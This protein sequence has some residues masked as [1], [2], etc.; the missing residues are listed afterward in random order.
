MQHCN[1][2]VVQLARISAQLCYYSF[3]AMIRFWRILQILYWPKE[4]PS[5]VRT[6]TTDNR[7]QWAKR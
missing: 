5:W 6:T 4:R 1:G 2:T 3:E 7:R